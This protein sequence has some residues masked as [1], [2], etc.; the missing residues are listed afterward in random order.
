M[1]KTESRLAKD[2]EERSFTDELFKELC[3]LQEQRRMTKKI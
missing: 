1:N 2:V 3:V